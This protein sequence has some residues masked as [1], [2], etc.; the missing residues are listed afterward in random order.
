MGFLV[1]AEVSS[2]LDRLSSQHTCM[3]MIV[4][5]FVECGARSGALAPYL[6]KHNHPCEENKGNPAGPDNVILFTMLGDF[7]VILY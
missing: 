4:A 5:P 2:A 7:V 6:P 3:A 1:R